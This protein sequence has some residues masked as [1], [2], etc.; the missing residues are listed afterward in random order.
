MRKVRLA[1]AATSLALGLPLILLASAPQASAA[2]GAGDFIC[3]TGSG[4]LCLDN[5]GAVIHGDNPIDMNEQPGR[6]GLARDLP[7][8]CIGAA[9]V[10]L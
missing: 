8:L 4:A 10:Q 1:A 2:P 9:A 7:G 6:R 3:D 5:A